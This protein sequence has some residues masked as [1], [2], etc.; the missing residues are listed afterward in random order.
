MGATLDAGEGAVKRLTT[1]IGG[2][3]SAFDSEFGAG[4][5]R[6]ELAAGAG[7]LPFVAIFACVIAVVFEQA[8]G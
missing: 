6:R 8:G 3:L 5:A 4:S 7:I 1:M 2:L